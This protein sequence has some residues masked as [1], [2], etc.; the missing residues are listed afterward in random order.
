LVQKLS[1]L[2]L[3]LYKQRTEGFVDHLPSIQ[4][5]KQRTISSFFLCG[6]MSLRTPPNNINFFQYSVFYSLLLR[7]KNDGIPKCTVKLCITHTINSVGD[8]EP[9]FSIHNI[10]S[11]WIWIITNN[12]YCPLFHFYIIKNLI[13]I[14][15]SQYKMC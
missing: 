14:Y 5:P 1:L 6:N 9:R 13:I 10:E 7:L 8:K 2:F 12:F 11:D 15:I 3:Y 4:T